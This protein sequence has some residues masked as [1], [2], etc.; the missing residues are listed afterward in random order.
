MS[1]GASHPRLGVMLVTASERTAQTVAAL[2]PRER[3]GPVWTVRS[4][5]EARRAMT[6]RAPELV[7][8]SPPL[9]DGL[10]L[11]LA[12]DLTGFGTAGVLLLVGA[13]QYEQLA[14]QAEDAGVAILSRPINHVLFAQA[15]GLLVSVRSRVKAL[16]DR[17]D[18]LQVRLDELRL[19]GRA[20]LLLVEKRGLSEPEA[21]R[22]I[23]KTA[24]DRGQRRREIAQEII[25]TYAPD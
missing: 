1:P 7:V 14:W 6:D 20:K 21:H 17:A 13:E 12:E 24:M 4:A 10:G 15:L 8:V 5:N 22:Y 11:A 19:V 3:F 18:T 23:E 25:R 16:E 9:P 2:L